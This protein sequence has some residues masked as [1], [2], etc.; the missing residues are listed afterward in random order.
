MEATIAQLRLGVVLLLAAAF[1]SENTLPA[2]SHGLLTGIAVAALAY[3]GVVVIGEPFRR[4]PLIWWDVISGFVDWGFITAL[5]L[6]AGGARSQFYLLYFLSILS[7][8]MRYGL[9][10]VLIAGMG[11][12]LG[13]LLVVLAM[14][15]TLQLGPQGS[16]I[17]IGYLMLFT[18]ATGALAQEINRH[19]RA[20]VEEK[21]QRRAVQK[22]MATV[23]HDLRNPLAAIICQ[24]E[25]LL[26]SAP[27]QLSLEQ[28]AILHRVN[29]NTQQMS[30]LVANLLDAELIEGGRQP[31]RP[32]QADVNGLVRRIVEAQAHQAEM[33][34][35]DLA[36]DLSPHLP[37]A[38]LDSRMI[39]R[40]VAN[41]LHN[42]L[43]F[44]PGDGAVRVLTCRRGSRLVIKV[45]DSGPDVPAS[46]RPVL[47]EKFTRQEDSPGTGL[48][49]Y[50]CKS[51]V[52]MHQGKI[53]VRK[54]G[55]GVSFVV[56]LPLPPG[57]SVGA[58][59]KERPGVRMTKRS[60]WRDRAH[61]H[62]IR[63]G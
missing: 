22:M 34:Q 49:L 30:N 63:S 28:R 40:V 38:L 4:L 13:Y 51:V 24:V 47:F 36:L 52:D 50:I 33:K 60:A 45:W 20:R 48:G 9:R 5:I 17:R 44:T 21:A 32:S 19:S 39:E 35:I 27:E 57:A 15:E 1:L 54:V 12:A 61:L 43:K 46:L 31:F 7:I 25:L 11:T 10:E 2:P 23:S 3:A 55:N 59:M 18:L 29:A 58:P 62:V 56:E 26:E 14:S 41:L 42:A 8:A 6:F 16:V 53:F 37:P